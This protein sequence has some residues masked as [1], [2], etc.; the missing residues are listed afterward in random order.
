MADKNMELYNQL[1]TPPNDAVKP[2]KAGK[3]KGKS[4]INT[5]WRY[6]ALTAVFGPCGV[7][8]KY[9]IADVKMIDVTAT[10]ETMVF[11]LVK[12]QWFDKESDK[13]SEPIFGWGGDFI[14]V[15]DKW[16][17][18]GNDE[19][20][21]MATT[22]AVGTAAKQLGV[23]ADV[24]RGY[25]DKGVSDSKYQEY[26]YASQTAQNG[27]GRA[28]NVKLNTSSTANPIKEA[29]HE[30]NEKIKSLNLPREKVEELC[31]NHFRT[32]EWEQLNVGQIKKFT[33]YLEKWAK[34]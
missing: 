34:E 23:G 7:G 33:F 27:A 11:V 1:C 30:F 19:A 25:I 3:L 17:L 5:Q 21:K 2:I 28:Q 29:T 31:Q 6:E 9:E 22:D 16:G 26:D 8:W 4:D 14:I 32:T 10:K 13:W 15:K 24:Y 12:L 18:H 20:M